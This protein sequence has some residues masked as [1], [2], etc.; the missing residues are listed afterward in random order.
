M[1]S[2]PDVTAHAPRRDAI[3]GNGSENGEEPKGPGGEAEY[4]MA[5]HR[6][7]DSDGQA[8]TLSGHCVTGSDTRRAIFGWPTVSDNR[9]AHPGC[10]NE[11]L[12]EATRTPSLSETA[13]HPKIAVFW[14][15]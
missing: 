14:M 10:R 1:R 5:I 2:I 12:F 9:W 6:R 8:L 3:R 7:V 4:R 11:V 13:A 15:V